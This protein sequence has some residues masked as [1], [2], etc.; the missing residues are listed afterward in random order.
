MLAD[1]S[2]LPIRAHGSGEL[3]FLI[4]F[5]VS[6]VVNAVLNV[7]T[8]WVASGAAALVSGVGRSLNAS[9]AVPLSGSFG[10][11]Y[12]LMGRIGALIVAPFLAAAI[13]QAVIRQDFALLV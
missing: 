8:S 2:V 9:T 7:F 1:V 5:G 4:S 3:A 10:P 13:L 12:G 11:L 6:H